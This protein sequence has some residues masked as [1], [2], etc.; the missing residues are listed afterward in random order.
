M[1][2]YMDGLDRLSINRQG[3]APP[4]RMWRMVGGSDF[5]EVGKEFFQY[6]IGFGGLKPGNHV[7]EIGCGIGRMALP[8]TNYIS[9]EGSYDGFDIFRLGVEWCRTRITP[10]YPNFRFKFVNV[11]NSMYNP[12]GELRAQNLRFPYEDESFDFIFL[13]SVFTHMLSD[14]VEK[15]LRESS[16]VLKRG[17]SL[18]LTFFL[19][20]PESKMLIGSC[21]STL[22]FKFQLDEN[23]WTVDSKVPE[24]ATAF[25]ERYIRGIFQQ[26]G[27]ELVEP[28]KYGKWCR[29]EF[30]ISYQDIVMGKQPLS[31]A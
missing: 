27:I 19:L 25:E 22:D 21:K 20:T 17:G 23:C 9:S 3:I 7:L 2:N 18:F 31:G 4:R 15:Y 26:L 6:F 1:D 5:Y 30:G 11:F 29:R 10:R 12:K 28:I 14:E 16:R 24:R 8:L 13:T